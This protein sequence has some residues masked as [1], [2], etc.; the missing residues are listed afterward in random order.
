MCVCVCDMCTCVFIT[1]DYI[2]TNIMFSPFSDELSDD[3]LNDN[4]SSFINFGGPWELCTEKNQGG[5]CMKV[6]GD[7]QQKNMDGTPVGD[8]EISSVA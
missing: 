7:H 4:V 6:A 3:E 8:D 2:L 5:R 1:A